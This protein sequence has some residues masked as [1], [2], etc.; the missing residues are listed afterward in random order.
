MKIG[1]AVQQLQ[2][3]GLDERRDR[4]RELSLTMLYSYSF[5]HILDFMTAPELLKMQQVNRF[6]YDSLLPQYFST[7]ADRRHVLRS[8]AIPQYNTKQSILLFQNK[9]EIF[10]LSYDRRVGVPNTNLQWM[11]APW[12][13]KLDGKMFK[14]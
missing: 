4:I 12:Q 9:C 1:E 6:L 3:L 7:T 5:T 11:E 13:L 8:M 10:N 2:G 14:F